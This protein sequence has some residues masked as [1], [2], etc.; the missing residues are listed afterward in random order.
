MKALSC[1]GS[2]SAGNFTPM[3][4]FIALF[5]ISAVLSFLLT[6]RWKWKQRALTLEK[7]RQQLIERV[8]RMEVENHNFF[9]KFIKTKSEDSDEILDADILEINNDR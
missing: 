1:A 2:A 6:N 7:D 4:E 9:M 8:S 3:I 5:S